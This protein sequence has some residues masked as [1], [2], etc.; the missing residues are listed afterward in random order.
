MAAIDTKISAGISVITKAKGATPSN[1]NSAM[2]RVSEGRIL[3][4]MNKP[5][6]SN[7]PAPS[8][9]IKNANCGTSNPRSSMIYVK[10]NGPCM[11][12]T[13]ITMACTEKKICRSRSCATWPRMARSKAGRVVADVP[14][15][16]SVLT[17]SGNL[18]KTKSGI[19]EVMAAITMS[20]RGATSANNV[21][22]ISGA[23]NCKD[24]NVAPRNALAVTISVSLSRYPVSIIVSP[25][26]MKTPMPVAQPI[27][28]RKTGSEEP[29]AATHRIAPYSAQA[30]VSTGAR[31]FARVR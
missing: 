10:I 6:L 28:S 27:S 19:I 16:S 1:V 18:A 29:S 8:A 20:I 17:S 14:V 2:I 15:C 24:C 7:A 31:R 11:P 25:A 9:A 5:A 26:L 30:H 21:P 3:V 12:K 22:A 13:I 23:I 4:Q